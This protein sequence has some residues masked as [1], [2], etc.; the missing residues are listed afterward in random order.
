MQKLY[1]VRKRRNKYKRCKIILL[2]NLF[3]H[4]SVAYGTITNKIVAVIT[5]IWTR[6]CD[7]KYKWSATAQEEICYM[8]DL[9]VKAVELCD[10]GQCL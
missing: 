10:E 9:A 3:L 4:D 6:L 5:E 8:V 2:R 7:K 1:Y